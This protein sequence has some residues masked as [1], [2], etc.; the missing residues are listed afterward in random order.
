MSI[1][2]KGKPTFK[3]QITANA[4]PQD[5]WNVEIISGSSAGSHGGYASYAGAV[6]TLVQGMDVDG[7]NFRSIYWWNS[8]DSFVVGFDPGLSANGFEGIEVEGFGTFLNADRSNYVAVVGVVE[9]HWYSSGAQA[10]WPADGSTVR[11][12]VF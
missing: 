4:G 9:W 12:R 1:R 7:Q 6:G 10:W 2:I 5:N 3:G 11:A 8:N